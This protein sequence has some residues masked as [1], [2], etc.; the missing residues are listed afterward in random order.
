MRL[1]YWVLR[2]LHQQKLSRSRIRGG[3]LH[4]WLGDRILEANEKIVSTTGEVRIVSGS[5]TLETPRKPELGWPKEL[6]MYN[7]TSKEGLN[8]VRMPVRFLKLNNDIA[9]WSAPIELFCEVSNEV[10]ERSPFPD[11]FYY[12]YTN[13]WFGYMPT[14]EEWTFGGYEVE[15]VSPFT[16][17]AAGELTALV[18]GY[19]QGKIRNEPPAAQRR[20]K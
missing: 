8:F 20:R 9:I 19:F 10:R 3:L 11:T 2:L 5:Q 18:L 13:G 6:T 15:R 4:S 12:G 16:P 1:P 7:R 17:A 14:S